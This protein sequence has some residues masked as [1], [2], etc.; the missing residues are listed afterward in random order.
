MKRRISQ[1]SFTETE[2]TEIN[3]FTLNMKDLIGATVFVTVT[4]MLGEICKNI[5][6]LDTLCCSSLSFLTLLVS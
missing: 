6:I 1:S 3:V 2:L 5:G 4:M